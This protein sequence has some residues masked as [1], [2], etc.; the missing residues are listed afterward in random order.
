[1]RLKSFPEDFMVGEIPLKEYAANSSGAFA[2]YALWK[3]NFN[4]EDAIQFV[5]KRFNLK[6]GD[7]KFAGAKDRNA[8]TTQHI[9]IA[10]DKGKLVLDEE[11]IKLTFAGFSNEPI[12]LGNLAGNRFELI[13]REVTSDERARFES[14]LSSILQT[15]Q[16]SQ[17]SKSFQSF[18]LPNYFDEQRFSTNNVAIGLCILKRD[19]KTATQHIAQSAQSGREG[20]YEKQVL[21]HLQSL[22]TDYVGALQKIPPKI[23]LMY[24]HAVQSYIFNESLAR[25]IRESGQEFVEEPYSQGQFVFCTGIAAY[26]SLHAMHLPLIGFS[27]AVRDTA[28]TA[29]LAQL[30]INH[31]DFII[32][33]IPELSIEGSERSALMQV[34]DFSATWTAESIPESALKLSFAL[35]KGSYATMVVKALF[36]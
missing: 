34:D 35:P 27:S 25:L 14:K 17:S 26:Q 18:L 4:T 11:N 12:S 10:R 29:L 20:Y 31:R 2:V 16:S 33:A 9:S 36:S 22:P 6:R 13:I 7:V 8:I 3:R 30:G 24:L 15:S 21:A 1:M 5:C 32:R 23:L 28:T 19:F